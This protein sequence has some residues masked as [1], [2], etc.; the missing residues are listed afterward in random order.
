[1]I[2]VEQVRDKTIVFDIETDG[3]LSELTK[4][5]CVAIVLEDGTSQLFP[6]DNIPAA[7]EIVS[8]AKAIVGHNILGFDIPAIQKVYPGWDYSG[9]VRDTLILSR[10]MNSDIANS[11]KFLDDLPGDCRGRHTLKSWGYRLGEYKGEFSDEDTDWS[12]YTDEMGE[13]CVQDTVVN[14]KLW[15]HLQPFPLLALEI[16]QK[17][18]LSIERLMT[19]RWTFDVEG[20]HL[21]ADELN[22]RKD[23]LYEILSSSFPTVA[24]TLDI[25]DYWMDKQGFY[26]TRYPTRGSAPKSIRGFLIPGPMRVIDEPFNPGSPIHIVKVL[27]EKYNW[28]PTVFTDHKT[29]P[30][31]KVDEETLSALNFPEIDPLKE[32]LM[33][34]K[35]LSQLLTGSTAWLKLVRED[36]TLQGRVHHMGT[37]TARCSHSKPNISQTPKV[38]KPYGPQ[39]RALY[40]VRP[41]YKLMGCDAS[42]LE[43]RCLAHYLFKWDKGAYRDA[44]LSNE[45][46]EQNQKA[47]ELDDRDVAKTMV[48]AHNYGAGD[49]ELGRLAGG[50]R[51]WGAVLRQRLL[52]STPGLKSLMAKIEV[53]LVRSDH[54]EGL[55]G[56][57]IPIR[58]ARVALNALLQTAGSV[59]MKVATYLMDEEF[60]ARGWGTD[61][62]ALLG[63]FHDEVQIEIREDLAVEVGEIAAECMRRTSSILELNCPMDGEPKIG[64]NWAETH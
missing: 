57:P 4:V 1:V 59:I 22:T 25:P 61:V 49:A 7:L 29:N 62:V 20:A 26:E 11:D 21:L 34:K 3:F 54:L 51:K 14:L 63:H 12:T 28:K 32:Y 41:G 42:G 9:V 55:D 64:A 17:F 52:D 45:I 56:R 44:V 48:Y 19:N 33:V 15:E 50:D 58:S 16:E 37:G 10:V 27:T 24:K 8:A 2:T 30:K 35:R 38:K 47:L 46:H 40:G 18:F 6:P 36:G 53:I 31:P 13:Y 5:H 39:C 60:A 43:L 23:E